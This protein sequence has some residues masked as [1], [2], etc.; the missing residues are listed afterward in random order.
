MNKIQKCAYLR[1]RAETILTLAQRVVGTQSN[2]ESKVLER[3]LGTRNLAEVLN[4]LRGTLERCSLDRRLSHVARLRLR[5][6]TGRLGTV[7]LN[8]GLQFVPLPTRSGP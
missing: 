4:I 5:H 2:V 8:H 6:Y 1:D 3:I 7:T